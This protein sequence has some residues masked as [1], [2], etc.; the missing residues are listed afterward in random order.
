MADILV[1]ATRP[2]LKVRSPGLNKNGL[3]AIRRRTWLGWRRPMRSVLAGITSFVDGNKRT[4]WAA[5][6]LFLKANGVS[7][8][9]AGSESVEKMVSLAEGVLSEDDFA[10]WLRGCMVL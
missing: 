10:G 1:S 9:A 4:G 2:C 7:I 3:M 8:G 5:C 6:V